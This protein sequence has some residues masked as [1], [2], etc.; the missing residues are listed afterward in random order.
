ML[1]WP[2]VVDR[3]ASVVDG[4]PPD[5]RGHVVIFT[6]N[7]SQA[8]AVDFYGP[9]LGLPAAISGHNTFWL[10]GYDHPTP[11]ATV[12]AVG[13]PPSFLHRYWTSVVPATTL[14]RGGPPIDPQ[15]RGVTVWVCRGQR[16]TWAAIWRA[17]RHYD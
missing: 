10:W 7:Y 9:G 15:E 17:A 11:G 4:L 3:I 14:G 2:H 13:L 8:G 12:V 5:S 16:S 1:G 6:A